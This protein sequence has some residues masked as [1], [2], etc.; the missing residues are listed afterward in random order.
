M[1]TRDRILEAALEL[2]NK[3]GSANVT[4]H[5]IAAECGI[6][7]GNLYYHFRNKTEIIRALFDRSLLESKAH[8]EVNISAE[9]ESAVEIGIEFAKDYSWRY[10]FLKYELPQ[11]LRQDDVLRDKFNKF[12]HEYLTNV[13][14]SIEQ[15][16]GL[17]GLIPLKA[18][19]RAYLAEL[20]WFFALFWP[21]FIEVKGDDPTRENLSRGME[22]LYW[23]FTGPLAVKRNGVHSGDTE[24]WSQE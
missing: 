9:Y 1:S 15:A 10:R 17:G 20:T 18:E 23:L 4:T 11:L 24:Q 2:F 14:A 21:S 6:S 8:G 12:N 13:E 22:I 16:I 3:N 7:P 5:H 19:E